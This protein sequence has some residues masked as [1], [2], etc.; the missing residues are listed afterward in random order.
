M[1]LKLFFLKKD[2]HLMLQFSLST[3]VAVLHIFSYGIFLF[4]LLS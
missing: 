4:Y 3:A 2:V 1:D